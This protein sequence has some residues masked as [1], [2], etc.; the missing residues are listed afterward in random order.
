MV[1]DRSVDPLIRFRIMV[2][3]DPMISALR[4]GP[5]VSGCGLCDIHRVFF[6]VVKSRV[7]KLG[8]PCRTKIYRL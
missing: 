6:K 3:R 7:E 5:A 8:S 1:F 2:R 4:M